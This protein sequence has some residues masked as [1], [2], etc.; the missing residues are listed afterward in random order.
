MMSEKDFQDAAAILNW[1]KSSHSLVA[2]SAGGE[3]MNEYKT[4]SRWALRTL[5]MAEHFGTKN[6]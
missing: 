5:L 3:R 4:H 2:G 6:Y 1:D